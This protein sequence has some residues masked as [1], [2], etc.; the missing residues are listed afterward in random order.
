MYIAELFQFQRRVYVQWER[1]KTLD[2]E[3][4]LLFLSFPL[5]CNTLNSKVSNFNTRHVQ[6]GKTTWLRFKRTQKESWA[7]ILALGLHPNGVVPEIGNYI[8]WS[9]AQLRSKFRYWATLI[10]RFC[11]YFFWSKCFCVLYYYRTNPRICCHLHFHILYMKI[12]LCSILQQKLIAYIYMSIV[13]D[14]K[15][16]KHQKCH[17]GLTSSSFSVNSLY[18]YHSAPDLPTGNGGLTNISTG[19]GTCTAKCSSPAVASVLESE[20][21]DD[22]QRGSTVIHPKPDM[23]TS[24]AGLHEQR[25]EETFHIGWPK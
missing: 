3:R 15:N 19:F 13:I 14:M 1:L 7:F 25:R 5:L 23:A 22:L 24:Q 2:E 20:L 12:Y 16:Y 9:K 6:G 11:D 8:T 17:F 21:V 18:W 4:L 10:D